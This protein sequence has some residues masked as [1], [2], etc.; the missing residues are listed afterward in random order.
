MLEAPAIESG[1][2]GLYRELRLPQPEARVS[3]ATEIEQ[4]GVDATR[5]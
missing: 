3:H 1:F 4:F 5:G 2:P